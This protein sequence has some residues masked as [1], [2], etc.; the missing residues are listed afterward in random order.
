MSLFRRKPKIEDM[1]RCPRCTQLVDRDA[2][3]CPMCGLDLRETYAPVGGGDQG[4]APS[5][6][7]ARD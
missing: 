4:A 5:D 3:E 2:L 7:G 1:A 6:A